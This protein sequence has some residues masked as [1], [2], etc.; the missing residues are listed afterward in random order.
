MGDVAETERI[1]PGKQTDAG[2]AT[3][4]ASISG[5]AQLMA[6]GGQATHADPKT[7]DGSVEPVLVSVSSGDLTC[8]G[9]ETATGLRRRVGRAVAPAPQAPRGAA[10]RVRVAGDDD[11]LG[12]TLANA[13]ATSQ[14]CPARYLHPEEV[15]NG[16]RGER[17][18]VV[19]CTRRL[20]DSQMTSVL[21]ARKQFHNNTLVSSVKPSDDQ[22]NISLCLDGV[23]VAYVFF[24]SKGSKNRKVPLDVGI[25]TSLAVT[26]G[27]PVFLWDIQ[28]SFWAVGM[29]V[30]D[31]RLATDR[32]LDPVPRLSV[33]L[34][35]FVWCQPGTRLTMPTLEAI[36]YLAGLQQA[37]AVSEPG[38]V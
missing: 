5:T 14:H 17:C 9:T 25:L 26:R 29:R 19:L 1:V 8:S 10:C 30:P 21:N 11:V 35:A 7:Q 18:R 4:G 38:G 23:E 34:H 6:S 12:R 31:G 32:L 15:S 37:A 24:D 22:L 36:R 16:A 27:V 2:E 20:L 28:K 3:A 33:T 13:L